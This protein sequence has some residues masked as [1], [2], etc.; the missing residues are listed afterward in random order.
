M[1]EKSET[2]FD[3]EMG[4]FDGSEEINPN[5][6][7]RQYEFE[8]ESE[9]VFKRL[10]EDIY[11]SSKAGI[12]E[13]I[14]NSSTAII[15][16]VEE[17]YLDSITD[18]IINIEFDRDENKLIME[19]NGVGM[20]RDEID[21]IL[22]VIGRSTSRSDAELTGKFG[23]GFLSIWML[24][25]GV[26]G[27]FIMK[28]NPRGVDEEPIEGVWNSKGFFEFDERTDNNITEG[29][30]LEILLG[31][32]IN[33]AQISDWVDEYATWA[34]VPIMFKEYA[35]NEISIDE[36]YPVRKLVDD[37][38]ELET[39][40]ERNYDGRFEYKNN[41][42]YSVIDNE[43]FTAVNSNVSVSK[44]KNVFNRKKPI[45]NYLLLDVP[46]DS[47]AQD[48]KHLNYPTSSLEVRLKQEQRVVVSGPNE[49]HY[50]I[51]PSENI[52]KS[53]TI[54]ENELH[55]EDVVLPQPTG[56]R[57]ILA[58]EYGFAKWLGGQFYEIY[59]EQ[60]GQLLKDISTIDDYYNAESHERETF[61]SQISEYREH[62]S[63]DNQSHHNV[64]LDE[65]GMDIGTYYTDELTRLLEISGSHSRISY[66]PRG[67][68]GVSKSNNRT[69]KAIDPIV[70]EQREKDVDVF[71]AHRITQERADFV[72]DSKNE[73]MIVR[74]A[75]DESQKYQDILGWK[76]LN[77]L[78]FETGLEFEDGVREKH[79][80]DS[81]ENEKLNIHSNNYG[82]TKKHEVA[83]IVENIEEQNFDVLVLFSRSG[84]NITSYKDL[85][86][87]TV[88]ITSVSEEVYEYICENC[89]SDKLRFA[90]DVVEDDFVVMDSAGNE[91]SLIDD[92]IPDNYYVHL[93][94]KE[95]TETFRD[96]DIMRKIEK[97]LQNAAFADHDDAVYL[98]ITFEEKD[99]SRRNICTWG[100]NVINTNRGSKNSYHD[101]TEYRTLTEFYAGMVLGHS[102]DDERVKALCN[103]EASW[104]DG[105][106]ELAML[107]E[108]NIEM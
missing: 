22:S 58:D 102:S 20:T 42:S 74:I 67:K 1:S 31:Q 61:K 95:V 91:L 87:D 15:R 66:A 103:T 99:L 92:D 72:W 79:L 34:R 13:P 3:F 82:N 19:D 53:K 106:K 107:V 88:S 84:Y 100:R 40:S 2:R 80:D 60:N 94:P 89:A 69:S 29:T 49:G 105:G 38:E 83:D 32:N 63:H 10:A 70:L 55:P 12:R 7:K 48:A 44:S 39:A 51:N 101:I 108:E 6:V 9:T 36:E 50:V 5:V 54:T 71:M 86:T 16:A 93:I 97:S 56:T 37:Y 68:N 81:V 28:T 41:L 85:V 46:I 45:T 96:M 43:Y 64:T 98:P 59:F 14:T 57:D 33:D 11:K 17:G 4:E 26:D 30:R 76:Y 62:L 24:V 52:D 77:E 8:V 75:S 47:S 104:L 90:E 35:D 18:G 23:M 65:V 78:D 21:R 27:G 25:G 73:H